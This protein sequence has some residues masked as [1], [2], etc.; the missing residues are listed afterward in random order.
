MGW[1]PRVAMS[2]G[3]GHR[4]GL[5]PTLWWL[6]CRLAAVALI[7]PPDWET[8]YAP[9]AA[10]KSKRKKQHVKGNQELE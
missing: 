10:L 3:V 4:L 9:D 5:D 1:G 8:P 2:C 7:P 6:W